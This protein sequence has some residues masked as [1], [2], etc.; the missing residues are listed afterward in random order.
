MG[1]FSVIFGVGLLFGTLVGIAH[2]YE[3]RRQSQLSD[4]AQKHD[5][6]FYVTPE[7][8]VEL[9]YQHFGMFQNMKKSKVRNM[10][11]KVQDNR[12]IH[13]FDYQYLAESKNY[14]K[15]GEPTK[16][17]SCIYIKGPYTK[18]PHFFLRRK[19][20]LFD[21]VGNLLGRQN[22]SFDEDPEFS[23]AVDK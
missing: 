18:L 19:L 12:F 22:I 7:A 10:L 4:F 13:I 20:R 2:L 5:F 1:V 8:G 6:Q 11:R 21:Y 16:H 17:C 23:F 3:K 15:R 14:R 9:T